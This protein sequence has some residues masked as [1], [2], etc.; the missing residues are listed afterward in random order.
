[1]F[2]CVCVCVLH[3]ECSINL[4]WDV[5]CIPVLIYKGT[6]VFGVLQHTRLQHSLHTS[7]EWERNVETLTSSEQRRR[8]CAVGASRGA[9]IHIGCVVVLLLFVTSQTVGEDILWEKIYMCSLAVTPPPPPSPEQWNGY[10]GECG[11]FILRTLTDSTRR[12]LDSAR[13][14]MYM[15]CLFM[16]G[17]WLQSS[18]AKTNITVPNAGPFIFL[19]GMADA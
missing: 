11:Y 16:D 8:V 1:M 18:G 9:V 3:R 6:L 19:Y 2:V 15:I 4:P 7:A 14:D 17:P 12:F 10:R 5:Q 13:M